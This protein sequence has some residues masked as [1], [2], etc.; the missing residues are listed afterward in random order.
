MKQVFLKRIKSDDKITLGYLLDFDRPK[1]E[2]CKILENPWLNN[3]QNISC[4]PKGTYIVEKYSS[5]KYPDVWEIKNVANRTY[6]LIHAGNFLKDTQGCVLVGQSFKQYKD[7]FMVTN[8]AKTL[9]FLRAYLP[10]SFI[11]NIS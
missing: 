2:L 1:I 6:I 5:E 11:L 8:S 10:D 3:Q 7:S 9:N 4:I